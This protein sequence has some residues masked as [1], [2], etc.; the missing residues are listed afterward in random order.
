M[1]CE[2]SKSRETLLLKEFKECHNRMGTLLYQLT[3]LLSE[4]DDTEKTYDPDDYLFKEVCGS[5]T[6][7]A[8]DTKDTQIQ[9]VK[10]GNE[11]DGGDRGYS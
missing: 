9:A 3:E 8:M 2:K 4:P 7:A 6:V 11:N 10:G 1:K 5:P